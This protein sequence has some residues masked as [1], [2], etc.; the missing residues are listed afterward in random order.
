MDLGAAAEHAKARTC[1]CS[2][3]AVG[4]DWRKDLLQRP[5]RD[6]LDKAQLEALLSKNG[7]TADTTIAIYGDNN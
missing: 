5:V 3:G 2:K 6:L 1:A 7:A 4:P